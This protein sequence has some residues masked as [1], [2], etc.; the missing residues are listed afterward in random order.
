MKTFEDFLNDITKA[1][2]RKDYRH[3]FEIGAGVAKLYSEEDFYTLAAE[4]YAAYMCEEQRKICAEH[5]KLK[6][7]PRE[8]KGYQHIVDKDSILNAPLATDKNKLL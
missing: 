7:V 8:V 1:H 6:E 4:R 5:A 2:K 3:D